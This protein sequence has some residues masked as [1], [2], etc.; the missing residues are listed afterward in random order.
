MALWGIST[1]DESK[2]KYLTAAQKE[3]TFADARGWVY[4]DPNTGLEEVLVAVGGLSG[5][6]TRTGL[7]APTISSI[8]FVTSALAAG[9]TV[10][11]VDVIYNEGVTVTTTGGTPTIVVANGD[12]SGDGNGNYTLSYT[13]TGS[14][15]NRKRFTATG[16]TISE[17]DVLTLGGADIVLNGGTLTD[18]VDGSTAASVAVSALDDVTVTVAAA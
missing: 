6:A 5:I 12:E 10:V 16:L 14:T 11:T 4:R 2:P 8:K 15:K 18:T 17:A 1:S 9:D 3:N 13:G 7:A